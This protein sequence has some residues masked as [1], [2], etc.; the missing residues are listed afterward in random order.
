M[1][2]FGR[3][4]PVRNARVTKKKAPWITQNVKFFM[5]LRDKALSKYKRNNTPVNWENYRQL[6]NYVTIAIKNEKKSYLDN[7][8]RRN[9]QKNNWKL[10]RELDIYSKAHKTIP[11]H[12][13]NV[14]EINNFFA[15]AAKASAADPVT[16]NNYLQNKKQGVGIFEFKLAT[17]EEVRT[18]LFS[19][20]SHAVGTDGIG[21]SMLSYCC[22]HIIPFI[23]HLI[24]SCIE[25]SYF[26]DAWKS[27]FLLPIPKV[28]VPDDL[29]DL[30]P[31]SILPTLSK[32]FE[33]ILEGQI[34][35]Y[36]LLNNLLPSAQSG[37]RKDH[38]CTTAL[39]KVTDDILQAADRG[40]LTALILLDYSKAFDK[41]DHQLLLAIL[42]YLGFGDKPVS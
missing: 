18:A 37:F 11:D 1:Q 42:K 3:H 6:R 19:I 29:K 14:T 17:T 10:L 16:L 25:N 15:N 38:S 30:R 32:A 26:P 9:N 7:N 34:Q 13:C 24:N 28:P 5:N 41:L 33:R 31:I 2:L 12:L 39:L 35:E 23:V 21:L 27:S 8:L 22:P 40:E 20:K 36:S 4:A